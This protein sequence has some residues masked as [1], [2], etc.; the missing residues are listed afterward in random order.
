MRKAKGTL[1]ILISGSLLIFSFP[2]QARAGRLGLLATGTQAHRGPNPQPSLQAVPVMPTRAG[3]P[4]QPVKLPAPSRVSSAPPSSQ[5][6]NDLNKSPREQTT[7]P[8]TS[9]SG[10]QQIKSPIEQ[11]PAPGTSASGPQ[12]A[13][14]YAPTQAGQ[15]VRPVENRSTPGGGSPAPQSLQNPNNLGKP[16]GQPLEQRP[17]PGA[18]ASRSQPMHSSTPQTAESSRG[19][20][21]SQDVQPSMQTP[22]PSP[23]PA[24]QN[25]GASGP[26]AVFSPASPS[27]RSTTAVGQP[28][29]TPVIISPAGPGVPFNSNPRA[30]I[31]AHISPQPALAAVPNGQPPESVL[32]KKQVETNTQQARELFRQALGWYTGTI[33]KVNIADAIR[34]ATAA[35]RRGDPLAKMWL[36]RC[37]FRGL[38]GCHVNVAGGQAR[39]R[40]VIHEVERWAKQGD[41]DAAFLLGAAHDDGLVVAQDPQKALFW[42]RKAANAG[43]AMAMY[44]LAKG[45]DMGLFIPRDHAQ[46]RNWLEQAAQQGH[47]EAMH[48]LGW[49]Y[50]KGF[51]VPRDLEQAHHWYSQA[52]SRGR[53]R[54]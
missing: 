39:A 5:N 43:Q 40:E 2:A 17:A 6:K 51:G 34:L 13:M 52:S 21:P 24:P 30:D 22:R 31:Q 54:T 14:F 19:S 49:K 7:A 10:L 4:V 1:A 25:A 27:P 15:A 11:R 29:Q 47:A 20:S 32:P 12:S 8:G 33:D 41:R 36:A 9:A 38:E 23:S 37:A 26:P 53:S 46:G 35:E 3:Q 50:E 48:Y 42:Y 16:G 28:A 44:N 18:S 45:H